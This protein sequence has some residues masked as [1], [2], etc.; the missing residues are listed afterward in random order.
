MIV[1]E[2]VESDSADWLR[3]RESSPS[4]FRALGYELVER[5]VCFRKS[6]R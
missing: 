1:R 6:L 3:M 2:V 4:R 5:V